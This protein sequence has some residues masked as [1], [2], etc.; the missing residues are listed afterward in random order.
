MTAEE[1]LIASSARRH[2]ISKVSIEHAYRNPVRVEEVD[3]DMTMVI[4]SDD[5]GNLV[6]IGVVESERGP[7]VVHAMSARLKYLRPRR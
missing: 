6:E 7:I 3:E 2:G 1:V 5:A 4:G